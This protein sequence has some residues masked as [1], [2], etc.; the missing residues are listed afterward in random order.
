MLCIDIAFH[1]YPRSSSALF[2]HC[3]TLSNIQPMHGFLQVVILP[4]NKDDCL[5]ASSESLP[6]CLKQT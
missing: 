5:N 1:R 2:H 3:H 4:Q 6:F